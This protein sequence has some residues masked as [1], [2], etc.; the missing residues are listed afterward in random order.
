MKLTHIQ[1]LYN[2]LSLHVMK[3]Q[4]PNFVT[5]LYIICIILPLHFICIGT[6]VLFRYWEAHSYTDWDDTQK[7]YC[8]ISFHVTKIRVQFRDEILGKIFTISSRHACTVLLG[9]V[10][11]QLYQTIK[12]V[13][14]FYIVHH[15]EPHV[16]S[17]WSTYRS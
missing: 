2:I 4:A 15:S 7:L 14:N 1:E 17:L 6:P 8:T 10:L 9:L 13:V 11:K 12:A 5:K 3:T 16:F